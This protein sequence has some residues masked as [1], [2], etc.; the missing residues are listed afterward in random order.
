MSK[1]YCGIGSRSIPDDIFRLMNDVGFYLAQQGWT[2]RS[3]GAEGSDFAFEDGC[4]A[5]GG[6]KEIYLPWPGFNQSKSELFGPSQPAFD[7]AAKYHP[8][9]DSL[10]QGGKCCIARNCY[11]VLGADLATPAKMVICWTH[12]GEASGGTGQAIRIANDRK[13]QVFNLFKPAD[14]AR[15]EEKVADWKEKYINYIA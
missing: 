13:I 4:N 2:L 9:W 5:A 12:D 8:A 7:L 14:R 1:I 15:I 3:G 6:K 11:Q 10:K